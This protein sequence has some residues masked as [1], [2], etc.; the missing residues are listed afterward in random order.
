[1]DDGVSMRIGGIEPGFED[2]FNI[3][4]PVLDTSP[5]E[6]QVPRH[7]PAEDGSGP[8][9]TLTLTWQC[10]EAVSAFDGSDRTCRDS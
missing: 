8:V 1:M 5:I 9:E 3:R 7:E 2:F 10:E 4:G 6:Y